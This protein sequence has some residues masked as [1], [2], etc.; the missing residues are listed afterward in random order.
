MSRVTKQRWQNATVYMLENDRLVVSI[1]PELGSNL[2]GIRDRVRDRDVL[3]QPETTEQLVEK[4]VHYG[5]PIL[6]PPNRI[7]KGTFTYNGNP[8]HFDI[9]VPNGNHIHGLHKVQPWKITS[10][11]EADGESSITT[12]LYTKDF[13]D[14]MRQYPHELEIEMTVRLEESTIVQSFAF[15]NHSDQPAPFGF[16]LHTW[17]RIDGD[18]ENW[19]LRLPVSGFWELDEEL[20][21]TGKIEQ[22][23]R[24]EKLTE[25]M[26]LLGADLDTV[27]QI[28]D[29]ERIA[30]LS[31]EGYE[32]RYRLSPEF[33]QWVIYTM[34]EANEFI[35]LEP[36]TWVTNAPNLNLPPEVTGVRAIAPGETL[37]IETQLDVLHT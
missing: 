11:D 5:T 29:N 25:G 18:P 27:F 8:Y 19:T 21:P 26:S 13:P 24:Y 36:Y 6:F 32:I 33:G 14:W 23:G 2:I 16:G 31:K 28:G 9:N 30:V 4:P 20:I 7:H 34:G 10:I 22:L 1:C 15:T 37:R 3:R 35:C 17:F 12:T